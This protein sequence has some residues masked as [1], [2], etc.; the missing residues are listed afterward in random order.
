[1]SDPHQSFIDSG[2]LSVA[3]SRQIHISR[4]G[5]QPHIRA[6]AAR[7]VFEDAESDGADDESSSSAHSSDNDNQDASA[8]RVFPS[9]TRSSQ[10]T[11]AAQ[12]GTH[13]GDD[14]P[15]TTARR[16]STHVHIRTMAQKGFSDSDSEGETDDSG[17]FVS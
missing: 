9:N 3:V 6:M 1:M 8:A 5:T 7:G 12:S 14:M 16:R 4:R 17:A 13:T 10:A 2:G 15:I 11:S